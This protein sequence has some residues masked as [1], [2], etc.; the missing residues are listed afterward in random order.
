MRDDGRPSVD[1]HELPAALR[2]RTPPQRRRDSQQERCTMLLK[3]KICSWAVALAAIT[4]VA[5][6][7]MPDTDAE[8]TY[9]L[10][11]TSADETAFTMNVSVSSGTGESTFVGMVGL[12]ESS[13]ETVAHGMLMHYRSGDLAPRGHL[14]GESI[15]CGQPG[16][17]VVGQVGGSGVFY[18]YESA[19][20][21]V[22]L[23]RVLLA[24]RSPT[25]PVIELR[26]TV[27]W[28]LRPV[29]FAFTTTTGAESES[30]GVQ[31][32]TIGAEAF[33]RAEADGFQDGSVAM[34]ELPCAPLDFGVPIGAGRATLTGGTTSPTTTCAGESSEP[35]A[36]I[37]ADV[38]TWVFAAE[39]AAVGL[40]GTFDTRLMVSEVPTVPAC[41]RSDFF[42]CRS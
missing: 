23:T 38:T 26:D 16:C 8:W 21:D 35:I 29:A 3:S 39:G 33:I 14:M 11:R 36:A 1:G 41:D 42:L 22:Q 31:H 24:V 7:P 20:S 12:E 5:A 17:G 9:V 34:A 19:T 32:V 6:A 2:R 25:A 10:E 40:N 13:N 28:A 27:G 18:A 30:A 15:D 37:A 4:A